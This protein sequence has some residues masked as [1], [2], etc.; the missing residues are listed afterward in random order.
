SPRRY[1]SCGVGPPIAYPSSA[2]RTC[3][4]SASA[5]ENTAT[6]DIPIRRQDRITRQAISPRLAIST[7]SN[8]IFLATDEHGWA[9]IELI[10]LEDL[11]AEL[12]STPEVQEQAYT[13][14]GCLEIVDQLRLVYRCQS[15]HCLDFDDQAILDEKVGAAFAHDSLLELHQDRMLALDRKPQALEL[16]GQCIFLDRLEEPKTQLVGG[17][18]E[19]VDDALAQFPV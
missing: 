17:V 19:R 6:V 8:I 1:D 14:T 2:S 7:F 11:S 16:H 18:E 4:A 12:G 3:C 5:E 13:N 10:G 15:V 9:R